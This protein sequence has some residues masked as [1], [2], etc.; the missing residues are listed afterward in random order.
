MNPDCRRIAADGGSSGEA[1]RGAGG[2]R[3]VWNA[4]RDR[5]DGIEI[6]KVHGRIYRSPYP[7]ADDRGAVGRHLGAS[8]GDSRSIS[9]LI[10]CNTVL[11]E[12]AANGAA[13][14]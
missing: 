11:F 5:G 9:R 13:G 3:G 4:V 1:R 10:R 8:A 14:T 2:A 12:L 6:C 7:S